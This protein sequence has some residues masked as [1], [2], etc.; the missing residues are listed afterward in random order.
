MKA[1]CSARVPLL[2]LCQQ[3]DVWI[4]LNNLFFIFH[5]TYTYYLRN[6]YEKNLTTNIND[7]TAINDGN[8]MD[9]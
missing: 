9:V 4:E 8:V 3:C 7:K 2:F 5:R 6:P 1:H